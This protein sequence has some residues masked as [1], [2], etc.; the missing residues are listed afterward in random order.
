MNNIYQFPAGLT[1]IAEKHHIP[2]MIPLNTRG[3]ICET[4]LILVGS[5]G[6]EL[7]GTKH[8]IF[9]YRII[10]SYPAQL[11]GEKDNY[12]SIDFASG[13]TL[14]VGQ[15]FMPGL[16]VDEIDYPLIAFKKIN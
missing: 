14:V 1:S 15:E 6:G 16:V 11:L 2:F 9:N 7:S 10:A 3:G 12:I 8:P 5:I 13:P 4:V